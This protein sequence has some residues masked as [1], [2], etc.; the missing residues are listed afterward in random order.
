LL[1]LVEVTVTCSGLVSFLFEMFTRSFCYCAFVEVEGLR[2]AAWNDEVEVAEAIHFLIGTSRIYSY[3]FC[4]EKFHISI[5]RSLYRY[6][7]YPI[8]ADSFSGHTKSRLRPTLP[9]HNFSA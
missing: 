7:S 4:R 9:I 1:L 2:L 5:M 6:P 8:A 3:A